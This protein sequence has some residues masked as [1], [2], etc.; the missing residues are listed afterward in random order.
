MSK[1]QRQSQRQAPQAPQATHSAVAGR[2]ASRDRSWQWSG[3]ALGRLC[4]V[5]RDV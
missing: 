3:W 1:T 5:M 4:G 2:D